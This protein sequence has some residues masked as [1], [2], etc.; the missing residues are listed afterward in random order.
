[1]PQV[2]RRFFI[3]LKCVCKHLKG[4]HQEIAK[5]LTENAIKEVYF[6]HYCNLARLVSVLTKCDLKRTT[7]FHYKNEIPLLHGL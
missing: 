5:A 7:N 3:E 1:M 6:Q 4:K 2:I